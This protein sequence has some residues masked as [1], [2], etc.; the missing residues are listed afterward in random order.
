MIHISDMSWTRKVNH[1]LEV[2]KKGEEVEAVVLDVNAKEQRISLGLKQA[3]TDPW[4]D[5]AAKYQVGSVV[6]GKVSKLASFGAFVELEDGVDGL[7]H[8]SQIS[9]ER[10]DKVKDAL[11]VGQEVEARVMK[12]DRAERRI[13]LSIRAMSMTEDE[14]K[15]MGEGPAEGGAET[16]KASSGT[17][18]SFGGLGA[19]FDNA[20]ANVEW[21]PGN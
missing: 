8:I 4:A 16:A 19:A 14:V 17:A 15:A 5:I 6:K 9:E 3:Q 13:G 7:V 12:V 11:E 18:D 20:F 2:L 10:V 1:P 21:Q